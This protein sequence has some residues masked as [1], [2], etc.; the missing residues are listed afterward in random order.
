MKNESTTSREKTLNTLIQLTKDLKVLYVEDNDNVRIQTAKLLGIY[1]QSITQVKNVKEALTEFKNSNFDLI[2]TD[3]DMPEING[4][5]LI[6]QIRKKD[7]FIPIVIISAYDDT[8]YFLKAIEYGIDGYILKPFKFDSIQ[9]LIKKI[10]LKISKFKKD[11]HIIKLIDNYHW[12]IE[13]ACLYRNQNLI[14]LTKKENILFKLLASSTNAIYTTEEI[15]T[16]LF[17]DDYNDSKRVRSLISR[18]KSKLSSNLIL[19]IYALG[20]KLNKENSC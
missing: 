19:S 2:F 4:L 18:L 5:E 14:K 10:T 17:N 15:E 8:N 11:S 12:N 6:K 13:D 1:F 9:S 20:Y 3:I 16:E 7:D